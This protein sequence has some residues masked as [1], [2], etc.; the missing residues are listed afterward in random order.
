MEDTEKHPNK[1]IRRPLTEFDIFKSI[2]IGKKYEIIQ[3]KR[4]ERKWYN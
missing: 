2:L 1:G 4:R 3:K